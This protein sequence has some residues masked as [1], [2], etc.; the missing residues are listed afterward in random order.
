MNWSDYAAA[1]QDAQYT[2]RLADKNSEAMAN[3]LRN[4]LRAT[5]ISQNILADLKRELRD[6]NIHT[7][8]WSSK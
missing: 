2:Q 3:M 6:F 5:N 1:F 8:A 7:G 4:R